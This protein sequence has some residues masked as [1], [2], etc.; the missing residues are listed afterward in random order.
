M[1]TNSRIDVDHSFETAACGL[2]LLNLEGNII[3]ANRKLL[4]WIEAEIEEV[5]NKKF[6]S[7]LGKGGA[8]YYQIFVESLLKLNGQAN[9]I[10][11]TIQHGNTSFPCLF[12]ASV[13][14]E[15]D[16]STYV[17]IAIFKVSDRKKYEAELL[18]QKNESDADR[19][20]KALALTEVAFDQAHLVRAPLANMLG[21][22]SLIE[23]MEINAEVREL[24]GL[25][26]ES[27][28][29]LDHQVREIVKKTN[30]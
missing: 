21:L 25:L 7:L 20:I 10:D 29:K 15:T 5:E 18:K 27:T 2:A 28:E 17:S 6:T 3:K 8:F 19:A 30:Q 26:A 9:E 4:G 13:Q 11:L 23:Q 22:I 12:N 16:G 24:I 1:K 14:N